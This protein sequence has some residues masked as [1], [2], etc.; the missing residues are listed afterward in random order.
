MAPWHEAAARAGAR[1]AAKFPI[2]QAGVVI[3]AI[4]L[5]AGEPGFFTDELL[6]TLD[7]MATDISFALDNI[8]RE[9]ERKRIEEALRAAEEQFCGLVEAMSSHRP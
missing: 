6:A 3:D 2:G 7:E 9:A 4:N 1:A 5:Y 8:G